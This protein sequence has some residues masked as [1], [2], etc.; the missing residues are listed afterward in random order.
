[1][2]G[3]QLV[4]R[5]RFLLPVLILLGISALWVTNCSGPRPVVSNLRIEAPSAADKPYRV[6]AR[7]WND[8]PGHGQVEVIFRLRD[9]SSGHIYQQS[10][11]VTLRSG[12][13]VIVSVDI[14]APPGNYKPDVIASYPP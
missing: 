6:T 1:M 9:T 7:V 5:A 3:K 14:S 8:G 4:K 2:Q 12:E 13:A 10:E 11:Q